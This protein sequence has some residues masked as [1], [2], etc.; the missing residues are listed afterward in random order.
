MTE[1]SAVRHLDYLRQCLRQDKAPIGFYLSAGCGVAIQVSGVPLI[2]DIAGMTARITSVLVKSADKDQFTALLATFSGADANIEE[3][4]SRIRA[5]TAVADAGPVHGL[6]A[7]D[8]G[9]LDVTMSKAIADLVG[10]DLPD[11]ATPHRS[12][13]AWASSA[14][15][16]A[17]IELF[18]TNYDLLFEQALERVGVPYFDGFVGSNRPFFDAAAVDRDEL[19]ARWVRLWKLHG[20]VNWRRG[21]DGGVYRTFVSDL[22]SPA[23]IHPSHL[24]YD[25]SRKMPY[26]AMIDQLRDFLRKRRA[27]I[28]LCGYSFGDEHLEDVLL[29]ELEG[30]PTAAAFAL[31]YGTLDNHQRAVALAERRP[32]LTV[33]VARPLS[34]GPARVRVLLPVQ[35]GRE[36][37]RSREAQTTHAGAD[38]QEAQRGRQDAG[39]WGRDAGGLQGA[40]SLG[41]DLSSLAGSS[42]G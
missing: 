18:T 3:L 12:L 41:G 14:V 8:L 23:L 15:R 17:P 26:L 13:A 2:P 21:P 1:H 38:R 20:S 28:V 35:N 9:R 6:D 24:K 42:A 37:D 32:N 5:L 16:A 25:E 19:P 39:R 11:T 27:T 40:R 4:L 34:F 33:I 31:M 7:A 29:Q 36:E 30:N 10:V 22:A